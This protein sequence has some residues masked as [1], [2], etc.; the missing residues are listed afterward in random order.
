MRVFAS[1][2]LAPPDTGPRVE[3]YQDPS[4]FRLEPI[5]WGPEAGKT[6]VFQHNAL[7]E[8]WTQVGT[9]QTHDEAEAFVKGQIHG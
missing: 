4:G 3:A 5:E 9:F 2:P 1:I 8:R 7:L 6:R